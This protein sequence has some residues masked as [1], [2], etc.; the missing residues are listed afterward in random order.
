MPG[1]RIGRRTS[2]GA[3]WA[4]VGTTVVITVY[5][6]GVPPQWPVPQATAAAAAAPVSAGRA[7]AAGPPEPSRAVTTTTTTNTTNT[8]TTTTRAALDPC[9]P[10]ARQ[11]ITEAPGAGRTVALTFDDGPGPD[12]GPLLAVLR[13]RGVHAT[14]FMV[15]EAA[16][17]RPD[18]VAAV[19][20][21]GHLI[22]D[23][24]WGHRYPRQVPGGWSRPWLRADLTRTNR[25]IAAA[26]GGAVC[27][28][29]PPGGFLPNPTLPAARSLGMGVVLWSVDPQDW[30]LQAPESRLTKS[31]RTAEIVQRVTAGLDLRHPLVLMHD[32]GGDRSAGVAAVGQIIDRYRAHGY[33][34]VRLDGHQ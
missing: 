31:R 30:K 3:L 14:F 8:T 6:G 5:F 27:W 13:S 23:H 25:T 32:G 33:R 11:V 22:G 29:R 15:G 28:F 24:S 26:G 21:D 10:A 20:A 9:P 19:A 16:A 12:T 7:R 2:W 1:G 4:A 17:A 34:F 18:L